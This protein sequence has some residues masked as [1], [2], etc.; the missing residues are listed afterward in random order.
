M[1]TIV[2]SGKILAWPL[3]VL[4]P[5]FVNNLA[6][7][8]HKGGPSATDLWMFESEVLR[9]V[10]VQSGFKSMDISSWGLFRP[11]AVS[12]HS[13]HT[14]VN[15]PTLNEY[16]QQLLMNS[17]ETDAILNRFLPARCFGSM[18]VVCKK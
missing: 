16:E 15:K 4:A 12:R 9:K 7:L 14:S 2:E 1:S 8:R 3:A 5:G 17:I 10:V 6:R 18:C 13:L 11:M